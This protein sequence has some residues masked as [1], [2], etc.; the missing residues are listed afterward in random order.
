MLNR[1][2]KTAQNL[3]GG[4]SHAVA[5]GMTGLRSYRGPQHCLPRSSFLPPRSRKRGRKL[6][7]HRKRSFAVFRMNRC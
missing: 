7:G 2:L 1:L 4:M 6:I 5:T 3:D